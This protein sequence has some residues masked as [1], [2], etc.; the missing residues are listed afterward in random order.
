MTRLL[1]FS[2]LLQTVVARQD[3]INTPFT[4]SFSQLQHAACVSLFTRNGRFGCGTSDRSVDVGKISYYKNNAESADDP[5]V[6]VVEEFA[7]TADTLTALTDRYATTLAG[8]LVLNST[9]VKED[10]ETNGF[11]SPDSLYPQGYGTP[12]ANLNYGNYQYK[13]NAYGEDLF[14]LDLHGIP[15]A[16]IP[17][18]QVSDSLRE[19]SKTNSADTHSIVAEF[20]YYMGPSEM[21]SLDCLSW[22]DSDGGQWA[23]KCLPLAGTSVWANTETNSQNPV[24][25][26]AAGMDSTSFFHEATPGANTAATNILVIL[27][28]AK[29]VGA[30]ED[31]SAFQT[32][33]VFALFQ[34]ETYGFAGSRSFLR[35]VAYPGFQCQSDPVQ[36]APAK[37]NSEM[38]C[39]NPLRQSLRFA[40]LGEISGMLAVDQVGHS[41]SS[42]ML[43]VHADEENDE[44]GGYIANWLKASGTSQVTVSSSSAADNG[45]GYPYPPSPLTSLLNLSGGGVGGAVLTGFDNV[46]TS[47]IPYHSHLDIADNINLN[48]V[49]AAATL[50]ARAAVAAANGGD[51]DSAMN[52]IPVLSSSDESFQEL[53]NCFLYDGSCKLIHKYSNT[54]ITNGRAQTGLSLQPGPG[55]E[56]P[57]N[58]YVGVYNDFYGQPFVQVGNAQYGGYD[59]EDFGKKKSDA[60]A[61]RPRQMEAAIRGLLNEYLGQQDGDQKSCSSS[62]NCDMDCNGAQATCTG[63]G[64]CVCERAHYHVALDEALLPETNKPSGFFS[65]NQNEEGTSPIYTEPFWGSDVGVRV[66]R[67]SGI[68]PG[69][70]T[71]AAG[72]GVLSA[73]FFGAVALKMGLKK[74]KLI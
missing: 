26:V 72:V 25:L 55:M 53:V 12:S 58:Y 57:P 70:V 51:T 28:A 43:Y 74:E 41:V 19:E 3:S 22:K 42:D 40:D 15:I 64:T 21:N 61:L 23:P 10:Q 38:G 29:L 71:L 24:F 60:I 16:Y 33:I 54:E 9:N 50:V 46:F 8:I 45:N 1:L 18:V 68:I 35:D 32:N 2:L 69:I 36:T 20:N 59:G 44:Y 6:I 48:T 63:G 65:L 4:Q 37:E 56:I 31:K 5:V 39:L 62:S 73:S 13:W 34:A 14:T 47:K 66:Y 7:W 11:P 17:D 49:A 67:K 27:M 30:I 52:L